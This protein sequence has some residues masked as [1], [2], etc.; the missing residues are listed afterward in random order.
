MLRKAVSKVNLTICS[1][2]IFLIN[3]NVLI[4]YNH[5]GIGSGSIVVNME[6]EPS[7]LNIVLIRFIN[8]FLKSPI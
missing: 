8:S 1:G 7:K 5:G 2:I 3:A 6:N 4:Y